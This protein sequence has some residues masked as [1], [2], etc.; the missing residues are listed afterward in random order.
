MVTKINKNLIKQ[1]QPNKLT[2]IE[3][4][5]MIG[6]YKLPVLAVDLFCETP[7]PTQRLYISARWL[8]GWCNIYIFSKIGQP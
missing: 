5:L 4:L 6:F 7:I 3:L 1:Y 2:V 8:A